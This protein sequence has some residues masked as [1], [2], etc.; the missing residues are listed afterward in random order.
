[1][2]SHDAAPLPR[3][4]E[5][6]FD[7]RGSSR[8]MRVSWYGD[9]GVAVLSIWQGGRCSGTFRL[10]VDELARLVDTLQRGPDGAPGEP[11]ARGPVDD[12]GAD[13]YGADNYRADNYSAD[14]YGAETSA[15]DVR[16]E[17]ADEYGPGDQDPGAQGPGVPGSGTLGSIGLGPEARRA[18]PGYDSAA[19]GSGSYDSP[20]GDPGSYDSGAYDPGSY[21]S[22]AYEAPASEAPA[23]EAPAYEPPAYEAPVRSGPD[24]ISPD[25]PLGLGYP[26]AAPAGRRRA[27]R[28]DGAYDDPSGAYGPADGSR[29]DPGAS[30]AASDY[31]PGTAPEYRPDYRPAEAPRSPSYGDR[32]GYPDQ[33]AYP[34]P[35]YDDAGYRGESHNDASYGDRSYPDAGYPQGSGYGAGSGRRASR[36]HAR[37]PLDDD[38]GDGGYRDGDY[39]GPDEPASPRDRRLAGGQPYPERD[40]AA[41][42]PPLPP[43]ADGPDPAD[44]VAFPARTVAD[45]TAERNARH[46]R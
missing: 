34:D 46:A 20:G 1:M 29:T 26:P 45:P 40:L 42:I 41:G 15:Y 33:P 2:S 13:D 39:G 6:F 10:P 27:P 5:V 25:D 32:A 14:S 7:V 37:D 3:L 43:L 38:Y 11:P 31:R 30:G 28:A 24:E 22:G 35:G 12:Y 18:D 9:T 16:D 4:G 19:Y 36:G 17:Y 8:S 21:D 23:Y 44:T